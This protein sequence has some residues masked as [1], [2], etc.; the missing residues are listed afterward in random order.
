[1]RAR[2][3]RCLATDADNVASSR[4]VGPQA[5]AVSI[6]IGPLWFISV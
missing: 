4:I 2:D 5:R 1:M 3:Q 6:P